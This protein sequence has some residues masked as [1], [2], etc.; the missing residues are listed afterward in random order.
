MQNNTQLWLGIGVIIA[1]ILVGGILFFHPYAAVAPTQTAS[2]TGQTASSTT[3]NLGNG[4]TAQVPA[5]ITITPTPNI[6]APDLNHQVSY[7]ADLSPE[8]LA[9]LKADIASTTAVLKANAADGNAWL[10]LG[11]Y[12]KMAGDYSAAESVWLYMTKVI[13]TNYV[14]FNNLGDLYMNF[15]KNY[16][17]AEA[18]YL[19]V[20]KLRPDYIDTYRNLFTLYRSFYKQGTTA[21]ADIVALGLKNNPGNVDLLELQ[22]EL[23]SAI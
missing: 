15:L 8:A 10:K 17:K 9:Y 12:Y 20:I 5:G 3:V 6:S 19:Q 4:V 1:I 23:N 11:L 22:T 7:S 13:P 2:S 21:A 16:P 18:N 14:A